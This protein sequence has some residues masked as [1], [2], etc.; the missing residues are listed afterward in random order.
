M[1]TDKTTTLHNVTIVGIRRLANSVNGNPRYDI[2]F[3]DGT[4]ATTSSDASVSYDVTNKQRSGARLDVVLT[5]AGKVSRW[6]ESA[7]E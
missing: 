3:S 4:V 7:G 5:R 6:T 1:S 2:A